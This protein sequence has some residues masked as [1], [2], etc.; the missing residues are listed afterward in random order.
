MRPTS[1]ASTCLVESPGTYFS[2]PRRARG[3]TK[4]RLRRR[5]SRLRP[6]RRRGQAAARRPLRRAGQ[7]RGVGPDPGG[8]GG[9]GRRAATP[10]LP[11]QRSG[12]AALR[13]EVE[14]LRRRT[15]AAEDQ[16]RGRGIVPGLPRT[17]TRGGRRVTGAHWPLADE[18]IER[19]YRRLLLAY[20]G[21]C[22]RQHGTEIVTTLLEMAGPGRRRP[23]AGEATSSG[24]ATRARRSGR[25]GGGSPGMRIAST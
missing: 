8:P 24:W 7:A 10:L 23:A 3:T 17:A 22:R 5:A 4:A 16:L 9:G 13:G 11:A 14:R 25:P 20:P 1:T 18:R 21:S 19:H 6:L 15:E 2:H 12:A